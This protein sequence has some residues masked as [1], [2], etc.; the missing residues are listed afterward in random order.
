MT[1]K[2]TTYVSYG[3]MA[4]RLFIARKEGL[5]KKQEVGEWKQ[6]LAC[7]VRNSGVRLE[8]PRCRTQRRET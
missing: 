8:G 5:R 6:G 7:H 2:V 1:F 3:F 4:K